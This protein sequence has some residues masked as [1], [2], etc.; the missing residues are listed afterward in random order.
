MTYVEYLFQRIHFHKTVLRFLSPGIRKDRRHKRLQLKLIDYYLDLYKRQFIDQ[1]KIACSR[2][3]SGTTPDAVE[4]K[5]YV[6]RVGALDATSVFIEPVWDL[7]PRLR[8]FQSYF[9][10]MRPSLYGMVQ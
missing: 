8:E 1:L 4:C 7:G 3:R 10:G 5:E 2:G 9:R 6:L